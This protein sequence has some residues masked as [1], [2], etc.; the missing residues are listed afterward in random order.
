MLGAP[1][2][3]GTDHG[4]ALRRGPFRTRAALRARLAPPRARGDLADAPGPTADMTSR[5]LDLLFVSMYPASPATFGAQRRIEGLMTALARRHRVSAVALVSP[6]LDAAAAERAM[7]AYCDEVVLVPARAD[8]GPAKRLVQLRAL[9]STRSFE[10]HQVVVPGMQRTLSE[11]L[12]RRR[13]DVVSLEGPYLSAYRVREAPPGAT[14]P[15]VLVDAHNVE[16]VLARRSRDASRDVLRRLHHA[17]NWRKLRRE[18]I[19]AWRGADGV[20]FTSEDD[21]RVARPVLGRV[22]AAVVPNGVDVA[23]FRPDPGTRVEPNTIVFFGTMNYFPN[24]DG[25]RH[26]LDD[27]W[28]RLAPAVPGARLRIIGPHPSGE[29]LARRGPRVEVLGCVDDLRPHLSRAAVVVVPL[30]VGG[31]TRLKILEAM[32]MGRP[33]VST[34]IGAEG[35]EAVDGQDLLRADGAEAF[36]AAVRRVLD[37]GD[38]ARRLG[39]GGRALVERR[40]GWTAIAAGLERF[41]DGVV[42]GQRSPAGIAYPSSAA[43]S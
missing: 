29:V 5:R 38:L 3:D 30:R 8:R 26:F 1:R 36:A 34:T 14:P 32:A 2:L 37:D 25:M 31:G 15:A 40:Y 20:A 21:A 27:V 6:D 28:P 13:R 23:H 16:W 9:V 43:L 10:A 24:Q 33:V 39:A 18:E 42:E 22:R 4:G 35:I 7:R 11:V 41:L 12:R 17:V 19:A